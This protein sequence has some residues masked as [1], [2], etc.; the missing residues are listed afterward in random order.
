MNPAA[1][2]LLADQF[3]QAAQ[4]MVLPFYGLMIAAPKWHWTKR[5]IKSGLPYIVMGFMY[6][7]LLVISWQPDTADLIFNTSNYM[8]TMASICVMFSRPLTVASA[9]VHL[10]AMDLFSAAHV[11]LDGLQQNVETRHSLVL[12]M[13]FGPTGLVCHYFTKAL[14]GL[15]ADGRLS[16]RAEET[17]VQESALM[18]G[19]EAIEDDAPSPPRMGDKLD[20]I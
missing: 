12:C 15:F 5:I 14:A 13:M 16:K 3:F 6:T 2:L 20:L 17:Q 4:L 11:F 8:P 9:W 18:F 7:Y 1:S 10:L 19:G